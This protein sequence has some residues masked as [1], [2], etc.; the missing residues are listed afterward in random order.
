M[1][2]F[3]YVL[4]FLQCGS[5]LLVAL[6][7]PSILTKNRNKIKKI[8]KHNKHKFC[9]S[10]GVQRRHKAY[11]CGR[12]DVCIEGYD[13]HCPWISKCIGKGNLSFFNIF[14]CITPFYILCF[15]GLFLSILALNAVPMQPDAANAIPMQQSNAPV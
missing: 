8:T 3:T 6:S 14:L 1:I 7:N 11:H 9:D 12:C 5:Y 13:H 4:C 10:C 15:M 2:A